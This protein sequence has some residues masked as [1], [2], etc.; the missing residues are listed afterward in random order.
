[1]FKYLKVLSVLFVAFSLVACNLPTSVPPVTE[2]PVPAPHGDWLTYTNTKYHFQL[3]Y[4]PDGQVSDETEYSVRIFLPVLPDTNL[5]EKFLDVS[6]AENVSPCTSPQM[7]GYEPDAIQSE[8]VTVNNIQF[9][10]ESGADAGA[11]NIYEW[12]AYSTASGNVCV[13]LTFVLHSTNLAMYETPP[14]EFD[15]AVEVAVFEE[16]ASTF[17]WLNP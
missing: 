15:S 2:V 6:A 12:T 17:T 11:G 8:Q 3:Q 14:S 13:S 10:L 4:P 16:I 9:T 5:G 1:M 7:Q